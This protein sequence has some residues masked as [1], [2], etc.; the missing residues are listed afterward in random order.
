MSSLMKTPAQEYAPA[1][2]ATSVSAQAGTSRTES[3]LSVG[4]Y[5]VLQYE[6][7]VENKAEAPKPIIDGSTVAYPLTM[8]LTSAMPPWRT[9][10]SRPQQPTPSRPQSRMIRSQGRVDP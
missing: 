7:R 2:T 8:G 1:D 10:E 3:R 5:H 4:E 6:K 9:G